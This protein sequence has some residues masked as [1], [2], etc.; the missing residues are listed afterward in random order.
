MTD[1]A[2]YSAVKESPGS[3]FVVPEPMKVAAAMITTFGSGAAC[4]FYLAGSAFF[5]V[6]FNNP[7]Y[8][9]WM[10]LAVFTPF[11]L[12]LVLQEHYDAFF[13][14]VFSTRVTFFFR[15]ILLPLVMSGIIGVVA[16]VCTMRIALLVCGMFMGFCYSASISASLQMT[17]AWDPLLAVWAQIGN[18][19]G[20]TM[21]ALA[22]FTFSFIASKASV[23]EFQVILIVPVVLCCMTSGI[24]TYWHF[25]YDL[26]ERVYRR[27]AYDLESPR[28]DPLA[29]MPLTRGTSDT[30]PVYTKDDVDSLGVPLWVPRYHMVACVNASISYLVL[31]LATLFGDADLGQKLVLAKFVMD[32]LGRFLALGWGHLNREL[33]EPIHIELGLQILSRFAVGV[34][35]LLDLFRILTLHHAGFLACWCYLFLD[36]NIIA[37][38][39][40]IIVTRVSPIQQRK[41]GSRRNYLGT[42]AGILIGLGSATLAAYCQENELATYKTFESGHS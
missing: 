21:P 19:L 10:L 28:D 11:P 30:G 16:F 4:A 33:L 38:Q 32:F 13:D 34:I 20:S 35:L 29:M 18:M 39:I 42:F 22:F 26:F 37:S 15:V 12:A 23:L 1:V 24:L 36:E 8:F 17:A 6:R 31:P 9:L 5:V 40:D 25:K 3:V 41:V 7:V 2:S 27:L 14:K